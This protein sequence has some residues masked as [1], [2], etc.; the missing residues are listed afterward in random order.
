MRNNIA[1]KLKLKRKEKGFS[2]QKLAKGICE[3]SQISKIE[4]GNY[5]PAADLLYKLAVRLQVPLDYFF[6]DNFEI[7][8]SL[9]HFKRLS[10]KLLEDRNYT[11]LEY[12]YNLEKNK[13]NLLSEEDSAFLEW[14]S[15]ILIFYLYGNKEQAVHQLEHLLASLKTKR[16]VYLR[17]LNTLSNFY[18]LMGRKNEYL[19]NYN[20]LLS[21]YQN[22][23]LTVSEYLYG[24][25]RVKYN[26]AHYLLEEGNKMEA[27]K[28]ALETIEICKTWQTTYQLAPLLILIGNAG[29][30]I[31]S[32]EKIIE[33]YQDAKDLCRIFENKLM[34]LQIENYLNELTDSF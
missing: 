30:N 15:S 2:Q 11:D 5:M 32:K 21:I 23:D 18:S 14:T 4:R 27:I 31:I 6:N 28:E 20:L 26:Y 16:S 25:I 3:Q 1:E 24:Y 13:N 17:I 7:P 19:E 12:L 29:E 34:Y 9:N 10:S 8:S 22:E 33:Y